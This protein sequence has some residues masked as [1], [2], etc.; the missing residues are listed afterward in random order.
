MSHYRFLRHFPPFSVKQI[1]GIGKY[2]PDF[3]FRTQKKKKHMIVSEDT[4]KPKDTT[5]HVQICAC[6]EPQVTTQQTKKK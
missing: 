2:E 3:M 6:K 1:V 5:T 4:P